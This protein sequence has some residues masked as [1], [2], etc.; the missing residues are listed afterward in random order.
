MSIVCA[1]SAEIEKYFFR[2]QIKAEINSEMELELKSH[3]NLN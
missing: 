3:Q 2:I 1:L